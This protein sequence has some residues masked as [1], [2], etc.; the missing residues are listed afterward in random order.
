MVTLIVAQSLWLCDDDKA[1][2]NIVWMWLL[3][4]TWLSPSPEWF[5]STDCGILYGTQ[6]CRRDTTSGQSQ[7]WYS[8]PGKQC[9]YMRLWLVCVHVACAS[10]STSVCVSVN[11]YVCSLSFCVCVCVWMWVYVCVWVCMCECI[12]VWESACVSVCVCVYVCVCVC[13]WWLH[14]WNTCAH[15]N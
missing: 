6:R 3:Y 15:A 5:D 12:C 1:C 2:K 9:V 11:V 13:V 10:L 7:T 8:K 4:H 14:A